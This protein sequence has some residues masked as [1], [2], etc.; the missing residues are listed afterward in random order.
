MNAAIETPATP[1]A[2]PPAW[3]LDPLRS[4]I[5]FQV[6]LFGG[7]AR[8]RGAFTRHEGTLDLSRDP[9]VDLTIDAASLTTGRARRDAHLRSAAFFDVE[10]HPLLRFV[11]E[12]AALT[13]TRLHIRGRLHAAGR[14]VPL[15]IE[16][17]LSRDDE[18][19]ELTAA[20]TVDQRR[21]GMTY[22]P[23]GVIRPATKLLVRGRLVR[24]R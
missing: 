18:D 5:E 19:Y 1:D 24:D 13:G 7:L 17:R 8:V 9:A 14:S 23:A 11:S 15:A 2:T 6:G 10:R 12:S 3:R 16:A 20:A 22:S 21:L 4:R